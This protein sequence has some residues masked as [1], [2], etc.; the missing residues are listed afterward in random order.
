MLSFTTILLII[1][2]II[3]AYLIFTNRVE[4]RPKII[5]IIAIV[6]CL[7]YIIMNMSVFKKS[8][9]SPVDAS[10]ITYIP[11][12]NSTI[13]LIGTA[14]PLIDTTSPT[15]SLTTWI[16]ITDW[17]PGTTKTIFSM[18][19]SISDYTPKIEL[20]LHKNELIITYYTTPTPSQNT[21]WLAK[22]DIE[23]PIK[24][25][26][27]N[28]VNAKNEYIEASNSERNSE[29]WFYTTTNNDG[30]YGNATRQSN[31]EWSAYQTQ[32]VLTM[33]PINAIRDNTQS[34]LDLLINARKNYDGG[35][36]GLTNSNAQTIYTQSSRKLKNGATIDSHRSSDYELVSATVTEVPID[37]NIY[38]T[39]IN[40]PDYTYYNDSALYT[41]IN[42][43]NAYNLN[44][45]NQNTQI[46]Y[47]TG[48]PSEDYSLETIIIPQIKIQKWIHIAISFGENSVDTYVDGKLVDSHVSTGNIQHV[49]TVSNDTTLNWGGF[50]GYISSYNYL[51]IFLTPQEVLALYTKGV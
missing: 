41:Y 51:P 14:I 17:K 22:R 20:G 28:Y 26:L 18:T 25:A 45:I 30:T 42:A 19:N 47:K 48:H 21:N 1:F 11:P 29:G 37:Y 49:T 8:T 34:K 44:N 12:I 10:I 13:P 36:T 15:F 27:S 3:G 4:G 46:T 23:N 40:Q 50:I 38:T 31:I 5:I 7:I 33:S 2:I 9:S 24:E 16:N 6:I 35:I 39:I 43:L 32:T